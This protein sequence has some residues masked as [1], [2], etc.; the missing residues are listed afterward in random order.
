MTIGLT[1]WYRRGSH[2]QHQFLAPMTQAIHSGAGSL[3][4][5]MNTNN[6]TAFIQVMTTAF[7]MCQCG[8]LQVG[9]HR[10]MVDILILQDDG[11][12]M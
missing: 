2:G 11:I 12:R 8:G 4:E 9:S 6:R 5:K 10:T 7:R 3:T 1:A